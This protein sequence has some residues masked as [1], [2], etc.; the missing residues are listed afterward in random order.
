MRSTLT[1]QK[2]EPTPLLMGRQR[3]WWETLDD[4]CDRQDPPTLATSS[5]MDTSHLHSSLGNW[6]SQVG[7]RRLA[8][9]VCFWKVNTCPEGLTCPHRFR[10]VLLAGAEQNTLHSRTLTL[11]AD[12]SFM[13]TLVERT[14]GSRGHIESGSAISFL[15]S[16]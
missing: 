4:S 5:V 2:Q 15:Q 11:I 9:S 13:D 16:N 10:G 14:E 1:D 8:S 7:R 6:E 3:C 12:Y